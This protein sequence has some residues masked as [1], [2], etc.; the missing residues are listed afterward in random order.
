MP[1]EINKPMI[2]KKNSR[3]YDLPA[4]DAAIIEHNIAHAVNVVPNF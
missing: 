2:R 1:P 4:P 3:G